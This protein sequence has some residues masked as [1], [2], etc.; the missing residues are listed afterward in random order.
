MVSAKPLRLSAEPAPR[1]MSKRTLPPTA[2]S[3]VSWIDWKGEVV[4]PSS[5]PLF[6]RAPAPV[7]PEPAR[8]SVRPRAAS[9]VNALRSRAP[10]AATE[11]AVFARPR[12]V[13]A[14]TRTVPPSIRR[15]LLKVALPLGC[16]SSGWVRVTWPDSTLSMRVPGAMPVPMTSIPGRRLVVLARFRARLPGL[17]AS[18][19]PEPTAMVWL[20]P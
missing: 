12:F 2:A 20:R 6:T 5:R 16:A 19:E 17:L 14:P 15:P 7:G 3:A 13:F 1:R 8:K 18:A 4:M 10:P 11:M 9:A